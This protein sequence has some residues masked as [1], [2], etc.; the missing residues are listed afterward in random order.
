MVLESRKISM[1]S[2]GKFDPVDVTITVGRH[3]K[4]KRESEGQDLVYASEALRIHRS[5]LQAIE[6]GE[7]D[8]LP[9][10]T[11][12]VGFVRAYAEHLGFDG[13]EVVERFKNEGRVL[14]RR[15]QLN[16]PSP[17][18][19]GQTPSLA[20]LLV[21]AVSLIVAYGVWTFVSS[22]GDKVAELV[23][24]LSDRFASSD[25]RGRQAASTGT[26]SSLLSSTEA[27]NRYFTT[28]REIETPKPVVEM[29]TTEGSTQN[30]NKTAVT[31]KD[32]ASVIDTITPKTTVSSTADTLVVGGTR[33][34]NSPGVEQAIVA[35]KTLSGENYDSD[36]VHHKPIMSKSDLSIPNTA[37][38]VGRVKPT[39][40]SSKTQLS[41]LGPS[42]AVEP[43]EEDNPRV[44]GDASQGSRIMI[45]AV[46]D[47]WV[48]VRE[49]NG[50]LLL[51]R[52]L[53]EGDRYH[54]PNRSGLTLKT[55]NAGGLEILVDGE[56]ILKIGSVG[57]ILRNVRLDAGALR[58]GTAHIR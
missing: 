55:G 6:E 13:N 23:P 10:P 45:K 17:L 28:E 5:F 40:T 18:P 19:E 51:T 27:V 21:A 53:W 25:N 3:L 4:L 58:D 30:L 33:V 47:S 38:G 26:S 41:G 14:E 36:P 29:G 34:V 43:F 44:Y 54:V 35:M 50:E 8:R 7:I 20:V 56:K 49:F 16:F 1:S 12:A 37:N 48:E 46:T 9:G 31:E 24:A 32:S 2:E 39:L 42:T 52:V 15:A 57:K 22:P 11:Y